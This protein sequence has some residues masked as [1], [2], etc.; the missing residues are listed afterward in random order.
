MP[1]G[2]RVEV[3]LEDTKYQDNLMKKYKLQDLV[4]N[5][6]HSRLKVDSDL[7]VGDIKNGYGYGD[8]L[9][10]NATKDV[11]SDIAD[12]KVNAAKQELINLINQIGGGTEQDLTEILAAIEAIQNKNEA[13]DAKD[14]E[15]DLLIQQLE[16]KIQKAQPTVGGNND[17][18]IF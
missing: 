7:L 8:V 4:A 2:L 17:I 16:T 5:G 13:Q 14:A 3:L 6:S 11:A 18:L 10:A 1:E 15:I 12:N 9:D